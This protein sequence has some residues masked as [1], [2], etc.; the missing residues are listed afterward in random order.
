LFV[1]GAGYSLVVGADP[2]SGSRRRAFTRPSD[3]VASSLAAVGC[4]AV[5]PADAVLVVYNDEQRVIAES[6]AAAVEPRA[7][8]VT[9]L[10]FP[11]LSR[12]GEE[13][14]TEVAE[15]MA[16][17]DV[18][19]AP[20]SRSLATQARIEAT[21]L[22]AR[23][24]TLPTITQEIFSRTIAVDYAELKRKGEWLAAR[25]TSASAA[26]VTSAAGMD[27][28]L[29]LRGRT[30][31]SDDGHL[32][33]QGMFGNLPAGEGYIA[34][35]ETIGDGTIVFDASLAGYGLLASP[36]CVMLRNG[37]IVD[38]DGD[39]GEWLLETL[40]S[41][42]EHGRALAELGIGTNPAAILT[43]NVLEDEKA[44]G[45]THLAFGASAGMGGVNIASVHIDG[46]VL[47]PTLE[48][49]GARVLDD[50]RLL[51]P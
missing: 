44:I 7:R 37:R 43:G 41:G 45:T 11:T 28:V 36:L 34:P 17:A 13:P 38:A 15:A 20:T 10:G 46:V 49:D 29:G 32:Q 35:L 3:L 22:G 1:F 16:R 23:I 47:R 12:H 14:P 6:L 31:R 4:L 39:A 33:L 8:A 24:A 19:F 48:L 9:L 50:G 21:T 5:G 2:L 40:D 26:R 27:I 25:L 51:V 42:G 30:G 18:V